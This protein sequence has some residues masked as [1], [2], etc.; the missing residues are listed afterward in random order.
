MRERERDLKEG[1]ARSVR[2]IRGRGMKRD[3]IFKVRF[4]RS[5]GA[6]M[7]KHREK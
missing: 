3:V 4:R 7:E 1:G 6:V 2:G 5:D